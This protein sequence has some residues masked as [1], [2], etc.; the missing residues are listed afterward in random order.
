MT[1]TKYNYEAIQ[2]IMSVEYYKIH[3]KFPSKQ[4]VSVSKHEL[5][6]KIMKLKRN[7][8]RLKHEI[9]NVR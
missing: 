7:Q 1:I 5:I 3:K 6:L 9:F 8:R 2:E 4:E